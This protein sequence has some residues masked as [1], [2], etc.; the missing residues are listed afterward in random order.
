[1]QFINRKIKSETERITLKAIGFNSNN[2]L[3]FSCEVTE[4]KETIKE[5]KKDNHSLRAEK[6]VSPSASKEEFLINFNGEEL[7]KIK[8]FIAKFKNDRD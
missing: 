3:T 7:E 8:K 2:V 4:P 5:L 6:A 1:M